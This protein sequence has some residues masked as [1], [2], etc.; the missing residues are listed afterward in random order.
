MIERPA[1]AL[2]TLL[3]AVGVA[4]CEGPPKFPKLPEGKGRKFGKIPGSENG[5]LAAKMV[6]FR[7]AMEN[8]PEESKRYGDQNYAASGILDPVEA[9]TKVLI[10]GLRDMSP[11]VVDAGRFYTRLEESKWWNGRPVIVWT[12][13]VSRL[14]K[15][16][17]VIV[18]VGWMHSAL[19]HEFFEYEI[20]YSPKAKSWDIADYKV[21]A[22][23][24]T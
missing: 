1:L 19:I 21:I 9:H 8:M 20:R 2:A 18:Q 12:S 3:I 5:F 24:G 7:H 4:G 14:T 22:P 15:Q 17:H 11:P 6:A 23:P 10:A 13:K 16:K